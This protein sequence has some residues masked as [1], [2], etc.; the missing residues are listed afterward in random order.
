MHI[1]RAVAALALAI[2]LGV[3]SA[4]L[5]RGGGHSNGHS[6]TLTRS[7]HSTGSRHG[8]GRPSRSHWGSTRT[9]THGGGRGATK[10]SGS[11]QRRPSHSRA[12]GSS[13]TKRGSHNSRR[14]GHSGAK[15]GT[16]ARANFMKMHPCPS[17]G[18]KSGACPGYVVDHITPL[19]R[20]GADTPSNMQ[21]QTIEQGKAKDRWE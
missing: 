10:H 15:R 5:A 7:S 8:S 9:A 18:K 14:G 2:V 12:R 11:I 16:R 17:T 21:W 13:T 1:S 6:R 20:G 4:A 19:K 3:N